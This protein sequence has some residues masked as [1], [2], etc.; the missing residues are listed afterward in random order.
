MSSAASAGSAAAP[1][2]DVVAAHHPVP[3]RYV[4]VLDNDARSAADGLAASLADRYG[5]TVA[6]TYTATFNGFAV[7]DLSARQARRLAAD[8][9]VRR[10]HEDGTTRAAGEQLNPPSWGLDQVDQRTT[11]LDKKYVYPSTAAAVTAYVVDSGVHKAHKEFEGRASYGWDFVDN[12][13]DAADCFWHGTHVAGTIAGST[14]GIA[15]QAKVVALRSLGCGGSAPDSATVSALEWVAKN[16]KT[17]AVV[18][19]SLAMDTVGVGDEQ[20]KALVA[21]GFVVAVA[22]GNN[23]VDACSMSP[24]RVPEALTIGMINQ[25]GGRSGNYGTCVDLFAPGGNI[26]SADHTGG[27]RTGSG[28]SMASPHG[29]GVA[30]LHL[31]ANPGAT[32]QQVRDALVTNAT[33]DLVTGPGTGSPNKLLYTGYIT[34]GAAAAVPTD[35]LRTGPGGTSRVVNGERTTV[36]ANP[37]IIAGLRAGGGG[38]QG[39]SCTASVAGKR[40]IITAAHCMIDVGG[41]KSYVYGDDDLTSAG[42]ETFRTAVASYKVHPRYT[43]P[44][45]W[46]QG[47]DVA[48]I[49]TADDLPVPQSQ[50][51]KVAGSADSAL[52]EPGK[53][54]TAIGYGKTAA[55]GGS[56]VLYRTTLPINEASGCNVFGA[57]KVNPAVMVCIGYND[58]RTAT[59][60]GD[61]GGPYIVDGVVVG[62]VSWG[63]SNCDRYSIMA[64]LT[65]EMGDWAKKEIGAAG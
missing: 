47:Y 64:R 3:G 21:K 26:H 33:P 35:T 13:A 19:L 34:G 39:Q 62:V 20:I 45:S 29:A 28:T 1:G 4:V 37:F 58:G 57:V 14:V 53:S 41:A 23:G 8:P 30:A 42:D 6:D 50:W 22:A 10:V 44:N 31:A 27:Y 46:Q 61:S 52:T 55:G 18:N 56:G 38:P 54:G 59:C 15:K 51:V 7:R 2:G 5:G 43:G 63:S 49:T 9:A 60:S 25:G 24:S 16:G 48:V 11:K 32:P 17:P 36:A 40:K 12:D 65:N